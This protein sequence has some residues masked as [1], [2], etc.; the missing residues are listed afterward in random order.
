[1][2]MQITAVPFAFGR[3]QY[4]IARYPLQLVH[5]RVVGNLDPE[6]P[7]RLLYERVLGQLDSTVGRVLRDPKLAARGDALAERSAELA[8][9][10]VL[11]EQAAQTKRRAD[12]TL[13][14]EREQAIKEQN[15]ARARREQKVSEAQRTADERKRAATETVQSRTVGAKKRANDAAARKVDAVETAKRNDQNRVRSAEEKVVSSARTTLDD[16]RAQ[17]NRAADKREQADRIEEL[18]DAEKKKRQAQRAANR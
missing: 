6:A 17:R 7:A 9:A 13:N 4:Q 8:R 16:A 18:A 2:T 5:D 11:D 12:A 10:A 14:S 1:M 15:D 3:F